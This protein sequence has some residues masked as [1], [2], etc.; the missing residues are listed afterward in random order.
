MKNVRSVLLKA[1]SLYTVVSLVV[2]IVIFGIGYFTFADEVGGKF[3]TFAI[4]AILVNL[5]I[6][7]TYNLVAT[8]DKNPS[9]KKL[10]DLFAQ[11]ATGDFSNLEE[12]GEEFSNDRNLNSLRTG[13]IGVMNT[14]KAVIVGMKE[15]SKRMEDMVG[16]L[17]STARGA[18]TSIENIRTSM[19]TIADVAIAENTEAI[20]TVDDMN[21]LSTQIEDINQEIKRINTY[22]E[23]SQSSNVKNAQAMQ[24]VHQSWIEEHQSQSQLVN[25]MTDMNHD[26]QNIGKIVQLIKDISEQ[27]NLLALNASIEAARAGEAGH[28][29]AIVAEEVRSL[30]EQSNQSTKNIRDII[31]VIR[32]KSEQMVE[33]VT[34]SYARSQQQTEVLDQAISTSNEISQ[35]VE[36]FVE[37]IQSIESAVDSI[38]EKKDMVQQAIRNISS[39]I[40]ETSAGSQEATS[41]L[42]NFSLVID[43]FERGIQEIESIASILKFQVDSFK[44]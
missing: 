29:F 5:A 3:L 15:E 1:F 9:M 4:I 43:E 42:E 44:L 2:S 20:Q 35:I 39:S 27:T 17:E 37:S 11:V 14:F 8:S 31:E 41:S 40:G 25:E 10:Q 34:T 33:S 24:L 32:K 28:G 26:I 16:N 7:I 30:A 21:D 38:V 6:S 13:F 19:N 18:K 12:Q 22:I 36:Q 23:R